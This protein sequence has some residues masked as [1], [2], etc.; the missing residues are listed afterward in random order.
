MRNGAGQLGF[1]VD[2]DSC[3][4]C[5]ACQI[6]CKNK[7]SLDVGVLWRRVV[8]ARGGGW[9]KR[10]NTWIDDTFAF[11]MSLSC[12]HCRR[13]ICEEVCPT[14]AV[15]KREDGVVFIDSDRCVGC[16]YCEMAC[17]YGAPR[18]DEKMGVMTKC[19]FCKDN[20][21]S[22]RRPEC[23]SACQMRVLEFGDID[24]LRAKHGN[25][26][27]IFPLP[28]RRLTEP[29]AV[30]KPHRDLA[31]ASGKKLFVGNREEI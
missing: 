12:M 3:T 9:E 8:E 21:D 22:A 30:F 15:K 5:K 25:V 7:N 17:P 29:S 14:R 13:P 28:D 19:D 23:V 18:F 6:A 31:R 20:I 11:F 24:D 16:S 2:L 1:Y 10:G 26:D 4:G 27:E